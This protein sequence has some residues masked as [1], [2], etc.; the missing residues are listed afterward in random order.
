MDGTDFLVASSGPAWLATAP[1]RPSLRFLERDLNE[2]AL[3]L[4]PERLY[5]EAELTASTQA[6][7]ADGRAAGLA[8]AAAER[9]A[10]NAQALASI[11]AAMGSANQEAARVADQAA[12]ALAGAIVAAMQSVIPDLIERSA[13]SESRAMLAALLPG[14]AREPAVQIAVPHANVAGVT[15][16]LER[17]PPAQQDQITVAGSDACG[18]A[19]VLVSWAAGRAER[20]PGAV[21]D[22]VMRRLEQALNDQS[23]DQG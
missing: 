13:L 21:W 12:E 18:S 8:A 11:V 1:S 19:D 3:D 15:S 7:F 16:A 6:A 14:L 2:R 23:T 20:R 17:L 5:T 10:A 4:P 9:E 22:N